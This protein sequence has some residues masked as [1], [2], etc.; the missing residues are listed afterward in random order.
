MTESAPVKQP[1]VLF[2]PSN[3]SR[4]GTEKSW[5]TLRRESRQLENEIDAKLVSFS[6]LSSSFLHRDTG[7]ENSHKV[8]NP[9][10]VFETMSIEIE[11]LLLRLRG[12][13]DQMNACM[14]RTPGVTTPT[15]TPTAALY[16]TLQRHNEILQDYS[17]EFARTKN[18]ILAQKQ[19]EELLGPSR[20][21]DGYTSSS[22]LNRRTELY[23]KE[24]GHIQGSETLTDDAIRIAI[25]TKENLSHQ[26]NAFSGITTRMQSV[27]HQF[28]LVNSLVQKINL[29]KRR[30]ALILGFVVAVCLIILLFFMLR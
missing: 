29:R 16:H 9:I 27:T 3:M 28:P 6:K 26:R 18:N 30:D 14:S 4:V 8:G 12:V 22:A 10:H 15:P 19:R 2:T 13:N 21:K 7:L 5:E 25:E 20:H 1:G 23:L 17:Q 24:H 11:Q